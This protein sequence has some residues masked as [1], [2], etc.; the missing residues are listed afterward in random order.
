M[1]TDTGHD[2]IAELSAYIEY[3]LADKGIPGLSIA[4]VD[5]QEIIWSAGF[6]LADPAT[7]LPAS[8]ETIYR[9]GSVS[10][11]FT[12]IGV[13]QLV[14]RGE[15]DLDA[16][17]RQL[18][19]S[20]GPQNPF[21]KPISLRHLM[22]HRS[23]L[24]RE[25]PIG[26]YFDSSSPTPSL[27]STV[28]S[29][30]GTTLVYP[31]E[32]R[33]KYSNAGIATVGYLLQQ[34]AGMPFARYLKSAVLD[35]IG[36]PNSSF[37]P[38]AATRA[39]L[40]KALMWSFD[41]RRFPA[42]TFELGMAPA[43]CMYSN[44][45]DLGRFVQMLFAQGQGQAGRV[46]GRESLREM[47]RPQFAAAD[48]KQGFGLGFQIGRLEGHRSLGHGGAIYGFATSLKL[49]PEEQLGA[50]V[51]ANM[52]VVNAVTGRIADRALSMLLAARAKA[53]IPRPE[54][55]EPV[56]PTLR[57]ALEGHYVSGEE[58]FDLRVVGQELVFD[59]Q[60]TYCRVRQEGGA[61]RL[62]D[63]HMFGPSL[64]LLA[65][66]Q[67]RFDGR[68]Y[69]RLLAPRPEPAPERLR[70]LIGE[71]GP[72][73]DVLFV[74]EREGSL[75]AL[76]EW[77]ELDPLTQLS[78][79]TFA[80]PDSGLYHGEEIH[81]KLD[82]TGRASEAIVAGL[83]FPRRQLQG[84]SS[85]TFTIHKLHPIEDLRPVALAAKPP[86]E[87]GEFRE[88]DLVELTSLDPSIRLDL[89]YA[90]TNN[91][92][93]AKMYAEGRAF[94]QREAAEA[95][96]RAHKQLAE[97][98]YGLLIHDAYRPW[99][100]TKMFWDATPLESRDFVANPAEGSRHNR[101]CAVD[102]TLFE[103]ATGAVVEMVGQYD[104]FSERSYP[105]Y[106][107][108]TQRQRWL[109]DLLREAME[110]EGFDIYEYEWW[111]FDYRGWEHYHIGNQVI[112]QIAPR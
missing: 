16:P 33:V 45:L 75:H 17:V 111:H 80:F 77:T 63:R 2:V 81:F 15:L 101:G 40:A 25:P 21:D 4:L 84:E 28:S 99:Y 31:P 100:V 47:Y 94:M 11:L 5:G 74:F 1:P 87:A 46:L 69:E 86:E 6:G 70:G 42:P 43:G 91:F 44:V 98:G 14:E 95:V 55:S 105:E 82:A 109:R 58:S 50:I 37:E 64:E 73:Y 104:E 12:D 36:M 78:N 22:S 102:L 54:R 83:R 71:Y 8:A 96:V 97:K 67:L 19:P 106:Q 59:A 26:H 88:T 110:A 30:N 66:G 90:S 108:G 89:R 3:E 76:I 49:L 51:I 107:G 112:S 39:Q 56:E 32:S 103:L 92:M 93:Q 53:P 27:A 72:D 7:Q 62:N 57:A 34:R 61:L 52:D 13:M 85:T 20:F 35:P 18:L 41:G 24:V 29:L 65:S 38:T 60:R 10:K 48:A 79:E 23:G 9:I 68:L